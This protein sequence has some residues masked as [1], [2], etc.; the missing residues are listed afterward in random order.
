M[1]VLEYC[2]RSAKGISDYMGFF[3]GGL[4]PLVQSVLTHD[5]PLYVQYYVTARCNLRCEQCN[6]IFA[7]GDQEECSI[8]QVGAIARNLRQIGTSV[9]LLTGGEPF[10]RS[11]LPEI[12]ETFISE[13]VHPRLQTNGFA[14][15]SALRRLGEVGAHDISIS[16]DSLK[17]DLQDKINGDFVN[18]W[19]KALEKV[20]II[21]EV[22]PSDSFCAFG[23]VLS[24]S[25]LDQIVPLIRFATE[26]GWWVSLVPAHQ[27]TT[28][29][30]R[31]FATYDPSLVFNPE[32]FG[33]VAE[34]L[35]S[36]R[37]MKRAGFNLYDSDE[38]LD[39]IYRYVTGAPLRWRRR[40]ENV[41]DSPNLYFAIQPNGDMAVCCD[42]R[43]SRR[44]SVFDPDFPLQ[45]QRRQ[46]FDEVN[47][48]ARRCSGCM[49]GSFPEISISARYFKPMIERA[50]LFLKPDRNVK[51]R[52][53]SAAE[54]ASLATQLSTTSWKYE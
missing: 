19:A 13:G 28:H 46:M 5:N 36:V 47:Q 6:V 51:L 4:R 38:Y 43:L 44:I 41:C 48:I 37:L 52:R 23:C 3:E 9:V 17:P 31:S 8:E 30:P 12:A 21:S 32:D 15:D 11:D 10:A 27:T 1:V 22:F 53:M 49:Y 34:V 29:E 2:S 45:Y 20:A 18:S 50:R 40:N 14:S 16:L 25:N 33:R 54:L 26:I 24:P 35:N 42:Y 7:N 39:D